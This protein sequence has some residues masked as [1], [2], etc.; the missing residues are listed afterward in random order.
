[1]TKTERNKRL[2]ERYV[3]LGLCSYCGHEAPPEG[4][5]NCLTCAAKR[6]RQ[7]A[8][9]P[10]EKR[11]VKHAQMMAW[12]ER[13]PGKNSET[14]RGVRQ[15]LRLEIITHYGGQCACCGEATIEFLA[16]DHINGGGNK[17]RKEVIGFNCGGEQFYRWLRKNE[18]PEGFQ[19]LCANCN[20][21][22]AYY[23][24][25]PHKRPVEPTAPLSPGRGGPS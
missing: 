7:W 15:R 5:K 17:H 6:R 2:R 16:I 18:F 23:G 24:V 4:R 9:L 3:S 13:H 12:R 21:A 25:C 19:V 14:C 20:M 10:A 22:K 11:A 8:E 1:M